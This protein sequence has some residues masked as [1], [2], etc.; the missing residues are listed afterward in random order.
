MSPPKKTSNVPTKEPSPSEGVDDQNN[1][2]SLLEG[3]YDEASSAKSFQEALAE[4]RGGRGGTS[5]K[6]SNTH[7]VKGSNNYSKRILYD[8]VTAKKKAKYSSMQ[9]C[10]FL[11]GIFP[12]NIT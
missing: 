3:T 8:L 1:S 2:G 6:E 7:T 12:F 11:L 10:N 5:V 4:W 9:A